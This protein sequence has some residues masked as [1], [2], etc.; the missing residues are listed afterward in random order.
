MGDLSTKYLGN[1]S[2]DDK[3]DKNSGSELIKFQ[4]SPKDLNRKYYEEP[5]DVVLSEL[6]VLKE[7][8]NVKTDKITST[9]TAS[10]KGY[11][12]SDCILLRDLP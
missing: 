9:G 4:F 5:A 11:I 6:N 1:I 7:S 10:Q 3:S 8:Q 12:G 2:Y